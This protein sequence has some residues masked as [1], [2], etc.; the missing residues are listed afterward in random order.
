MDTDADTVLPF[1]LAATSAA[2]KELTAR[3]RYEQPV[4]PG[5]RGSRGG[6]RS[7]AGKHRARECEAGGVTVGFLRVG[8]LAS[9]HA[10]F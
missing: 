9:G 4:P 2:L 10:S 6:D 5:S 1:L 3:R 8:S 7:G